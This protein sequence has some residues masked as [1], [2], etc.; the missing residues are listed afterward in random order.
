MINYDNLMA[1]D[2]ADVERR[3]TEQDCILYALGLG[4]GAPENPRHLSAVFEG[5]ADFAALPSFVNVLGVPPFWARDP[6]TGITWQQIVHGEH[7]FTLH[8]GVPSRA[9]IVGR[10]RLTGI[11]DKGAGKGALIYTEREISSA[12]GQ[13]LATVSST[14]FARADGGFGGP[15]GPLNAPLNTMQPVPDRAPDVFHDFATSPRAALIYRLSGDMN[16]LHADPALAARAGF[17]RPILHGLCTMGIAAWCIPMA[18]RAGDFTAL[19]HQ[20]VRFSAP[21]YP[22]ETLRTE[23]WTEGDDVR[24]RARVLERDVIVLSHGRARLT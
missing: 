19:T 21:V 14:L 6:S 7:A 20:E 1:R 3:Y 2:F 13:R 24:F 5:A 23:I 16:P 12:Q 15:R 8:A 22:G 11:V 4:L 10:T 9:G 18:L 17:D